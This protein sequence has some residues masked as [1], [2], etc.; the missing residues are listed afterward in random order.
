MLAAYE[1]N[2]SR[3]LAS[4]DT[5]YVDEQ[6]VLLTNSANDARFI[7]KYGLENAFN[8]DD[9]PNNF[10]VLRYADVL[11]MLA[12]ALGESDEA[13]DLI[14]QVRNR[15]GL[16]PIDAGTPGTF[17]DKL[18]QERRVELAF[19]NHRWAD[20][21][22]FGVAESVMQAQGKSP[23]LLFAIPQRELDLNPETFV[24]NPGY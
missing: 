24:Q 5:T 18:L 10:V 9:A 7:L 12:E 6:G 21:K 11:L 2:D 1:P 14:N 16:G 15:A 3:L 19:E 20:L 23:N 13:Y 4:M 17:E 8:E 22:R